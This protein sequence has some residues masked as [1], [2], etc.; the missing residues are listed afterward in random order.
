M[1]IAFCG[2]GGSGKTTL[3]NSLSKHF[4]SLPLLPSTS[5]Q[6][7][8]DMGIES[9]G[10]VIGWRRVEFQWRGILSH[11]ANQ[12]SNFS[13]ISDRSVLDFCAYS[14]FFFDDENEYEDYLSVAKGQLSH[15]NHFFYVPPFSE[16]PPEADGV[17]YTGVFSNVEDHVRNYLPKLVDE[18]KTSQFHIVVG[19]TL[20]ERLDEVL[21]IIASD[22]LWLQHHLNEIHDGTWSLNTPTQKLV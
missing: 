11:I 14:H 12:R 9:L 17:R 5:R 15:Y 2:P 3:A 19:K 21:R 20:E 13:Y 10:E 7:M 6:V 8:Q 18:V 1:R 16:D 22:E 4:S